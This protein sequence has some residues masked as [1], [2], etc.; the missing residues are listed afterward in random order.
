MNELS[1]HGQNLIILTKI[2]FIE[3]NVYSSISKNTHD[4]ILKVYASNRAWEIK[5]S[6]QNLGKIISQCQCKRESY[7]A[8]KKEFY[9]K[10]KHIHAMLSSQD[11]LKLLER[12]ESEEKMI[13]D[14]YLNFIKHDIPRNMRSMMM[15]Q[16]DELN[17]SI[18]HLKILNSHIILS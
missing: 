14:K 1:E 6:L 4:P 13:M 15:M 16:M 5:K 2:L 10:W 9:E 12:L 8:C 7:K 11:Y 17:K 3:A 18:Q